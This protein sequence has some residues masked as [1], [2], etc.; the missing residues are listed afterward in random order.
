MNMPAPR[1]GQIC[2]QVVFLLKT[3]L[4][5]NDIGHVVCNDSGVV[6]ERDP[7]TV[8]GGDVAFYSYA[9]VPKGP[10]P[11]GYLPVAPDVV[12]EVR[13]PKVLTKVPEYLNAGVTLVRVLD[14]TTQS[15]HVYD[16]DEP[17]RII[18]A[19]QELTLPKVLG[20]FRVAVRR[21]FE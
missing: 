20:E 12:F 10:L 2:G 7:D 11:P 3:H 1:H 13:S 14:P 17:E 6:T 9:K 15:A 5:S 19:D 18:A 16:A 8:R 21:F 4:V